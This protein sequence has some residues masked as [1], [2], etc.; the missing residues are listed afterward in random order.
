[1]NNTQI[2]QA[3]QNPDKEP[4]VLSLAKK[5]AEQFIRVGD[6]YFKSTFRPDKNGKLH[7]VLSR[8]SKTTIVDDHTKSALAY[9]KKYEDFVI[10]PSHV[11][12]KQVIY[13]HY[14]KY[15]QISHIPEE[16][17][18]NLIIEFLTHLFGSNYLEF[19][20]DYFQLL[21]LKPTQNLP[22]ILLESE[23]KNTGKSTFGF[24]VEKIFQ[25][26]AVAVGNKDFESDFNSV[27]I[28]KLM[29][30]VDE[31]SLEKRSVM[32]TIK[33]LSTEKGQVLSNAKG[34]DKVNVE[35]IGKFI[36]I[37]NDEGRALPIERGEKR[38]AVF[39]VYTFSN[40]GIQDDP[41]ILEKLEAQIPFFLQY[42]KSRKLHHEEKTRMYF[43][44]EVYFT[45][46][47]KL[48]FRGSASYAAK[49]IKELIKDTF[50]MFPEVDE[51]R[52]SISELLV[53]LTK[54]SYIK[55]TDRQQ[56]KR[57]IEEELKLEPQ[58]RGRYVYH[59][60][61]MAELDETD[62]LIS[63]KSNRNLIHYVFSKSEPV[64]GVDFSNN[65]IGDFRK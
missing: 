49:A 55:S 48:Y 61:Y 56:I 32:Q 52:F 17:D 19:I 11:D 46:Q 29:I 51:L 58:K 65:T 22:I 44:T 20:L 41:N 9:I 42:L 1:M 8:R 13:G 33:R 21:Y 3:P 45:E 39:K 59:S 47:L 36:F 57:A 40:R 38:F 35:F 43:D 30:V 60:L 50:Q 14:N 2:D 27:W 25:F 28:D 16:G 26:N 31:T 63:G 4:K 64:K 37:S 23:E 15:H 7:R 18:C 5:A 12:Y 24:F 62:L 34:K 6:D 53:E 10:V 54:G